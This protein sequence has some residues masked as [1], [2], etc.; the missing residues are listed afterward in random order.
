MEK[1]K[2]NY[3]L[4]KRD[5]L[6]LIKSLDE[7]S[8]MASF[9]DCFLV[10]PSKVQVKFLEFFADEYDRDDWSKWIKDE[11][12]F[13][14]VVRAILFFHTGREDIKQPSKKD[15]KKMIADFIREGDKFDYWLESEDDFDITEELRSI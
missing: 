9:I 13:V 6:L 2:E 10:L 12:L 14:K 11:T 7:R 8:Y 5:L 4:V 3:L 1:V 15:L